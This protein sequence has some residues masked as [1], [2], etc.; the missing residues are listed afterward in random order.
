MNETGRIFDSSAYFAA[1]KEDTGCGR[2]SSGEMLA[3][4]DV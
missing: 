4:S 1:A 3:R 2:R